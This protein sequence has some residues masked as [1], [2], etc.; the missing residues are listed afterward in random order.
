MRTVIFVFVLFVLASCS[1][2]PKTGDVKTDA[3][4]SHVA[5]ESQIIGEQW[6]EKFT[7]DGFVDGNYVAIGSSSTANM[8]YNTKPLRLSAESDALARL[9]RSAPTDYK[10]IVK[11]VLNSMSDGDGQ[12]SET[13]I[14]ITEVR[15]LTG[16]TSNFNDIQCIKTVSPTQEMKWSFAKE[17]RVILRISPEDLSRAY[18]FTLSKKYSIKRKNE[19]E[20][21]VSKE[22]NDSTAVSEVNN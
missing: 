14:S 13:D 11:K 5:Q 7:K 22:I 8:N 21:L 16:V 9:L 6:Q 3:V 10:R 17:C 15:S 20:A 19:I 12:V 4:I 1:S 18:D 2:V